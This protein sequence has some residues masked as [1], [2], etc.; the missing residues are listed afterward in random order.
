M[1]VNAAGR[2]PLKAPECPLV[3]DLID[4]ALGHA[5]P[6]DRHR[7]DDHLNNGHCKDCRRWIDQAGSYRSTSLSNPANAPTKLDTAQWQRQA[8]LDLEKRLRGLEEG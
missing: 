7:I 2:P 1:A 3:A 6:E 4:Y 5:A 8:F